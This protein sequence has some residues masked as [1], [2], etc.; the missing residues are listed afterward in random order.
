MPDVG[1]FDAARVATY[2]YVN[3]LVALVLGWAFIGE[4]IGMR[5]VYAAALMLSGV[6]VIQVANARKKSATRVAIAGE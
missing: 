4:P 3:P 5:T 1:V 2:A 6:A